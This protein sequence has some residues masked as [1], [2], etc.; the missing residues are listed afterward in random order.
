MREALLGSGREP[1]IKLCCLPGEEAEAYYSEHGVEV[2]VDDWL[3]RPLELPEADLLL[4]DWLDSSPGS[5]TK[6]R[7]RFP[8]I[9][10]LDDYGSAS[11][12]ADLVV[13]CLLSSIASSHLREGR[14][15]VCSGIMYLQLAPSILKLRYG[16][17]ASLHALE[18]S[19]VDATERQPGPLHSIM[20]SFG[21]T[22]RP[23]QTGFILGILAEMEFTGRIIVKPADLDMPLPSGLD[24]ECHADAQG[25]H[26]LLSACDACVVGGGLTL[27]EAVFLGVAPM[28][29]PIVEHQLDTARKLN[30]A[31]CCLI[32]GK[33]GELNHNLATGRLMELLGG[34]SQRGRLVHNGMRLID[35]KGIYRTLDLLLNLLDSPPAP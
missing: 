20:L 2:L 29:L 13:R 19:L 32:G 31:G 16:A 4:I 34:P 5:M 23:V 7:S 6:L 22:P 12:E 8:R 17:Q 35:G 3:G 25:F 26:S 9:A 1:D 11:A 18:A 30:A 27:Y 33:T 21:G 28:V 24:V 14:A 15:E 10:L